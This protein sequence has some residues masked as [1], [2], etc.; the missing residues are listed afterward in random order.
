MPET[1]SVPGGTQVGPRATYRFKWSN[2][3]LDTYF[4]GR[5]AAADALR[6]EASVMIKRAD[7]IELEITE[8]AACLELVT[9][10]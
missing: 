4:V 5:R 3:D 9:N 6:R 7:Q 1:T 10:D 8:L 2:L